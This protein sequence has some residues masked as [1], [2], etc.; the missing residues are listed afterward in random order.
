L[1]AA[2]AV[3]LFAVAVV[4]IV[5]VVSGD[6]KNSGNVQR[7]FGGYISPEDERLLYE[8]NR[9]AASANDSYLELV[10]AAADEDVDRIE[11]IAGRGRMTVDKGLRAVAAMVNEGL[12]SEIRG[13]LGAQRT[14]FTAYGDLARYART[15]RSSGS[16]PEAE[17]LLARAARAERR[18]ALRRRHLYRRVADYL[19]PEQRRLV[20][21]EQRAYDE[22]LEQIEPTK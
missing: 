4:G 15:H 21:T 3:V 13:L 14:V 12:R 18:T 11:R 9:T 16:T 7:A 22:R 6:G 1:I 5:L 8:L 17:R 2:A 10:Q 20:R 19:T